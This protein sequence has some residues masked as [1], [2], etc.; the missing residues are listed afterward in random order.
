[1]EM[2]PGARMAS[3]STTPKLSLNLDSYGVSGTG[4][5]ALT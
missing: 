4:T 2:R 1:M 3:S 5:S